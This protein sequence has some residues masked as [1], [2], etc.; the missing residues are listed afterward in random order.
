MSDL[1]QQDALLYWAAEL[2]R[3]AQGMHNAMAQMNLGLMAKHD[4]IT[5]EVI[6]A[7]LARK[8]TK[9]SGGS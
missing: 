4:F 3:I 1:S 2:D 8:L 5:A 7:N 9:L 6:I